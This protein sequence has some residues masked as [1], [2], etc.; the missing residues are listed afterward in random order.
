M[1]QALYKPLTVRTL[2]LTA[3]NKTRE[4]F[5]QRVGQS[6]FRSAQFMFNSVLPMDENGTEF[7]MFGG[8]G[9]RNGNAAGNRRLPNQNRN[10]IEIYPLGFL[11]E[12]QSDIY[13][14]SA[15]FG[16]RGKLKEWNVDF[17][18]TY[19]QN[20]FLFGVVNSLNASMLTG[21]PTRFNSGGTAF[22]QNTTNLDFTRQFAGLSGINLAFGAEHR[23]EKYQVIAGE[24]ASYTD[25]GKARQVGVDATGKPILVPDPTG[26]IPTRFGGADS[27]SRPGGAQVFPGYR[28][29]NAITATRSAIGAYVDGE[30]SFSKAFLVDA[31]IRF[32]NYN[33]FGSTLNQKLA[34][35][36]K[37]SDNFAIRASASTGFRAPSLHQRYLS[38]T[39]TVFRGGIPYE[40]GTFANDSRAAELLGIPKLR[41]EKSK[42]VSAGFTGTKGKFKI[43]LDGFF[44]RI[45]DRVVYTDAFTG[46]A[47]STSPV[48]QEI[49]RLLSLANAGSASFFANA[50]NTETKGVDLV[51]SYGTKLGKGNFRADFAGTHS[52]TQKVGAVMASEKLK[53]KEN[54][55]FSELSRIY[56]ERAVPRDKFNLTLTY[57][58]KKINVFVRN[59]WFG[60]VDEPVNNPAL[61]QKFGAKVI[62]DFS[63][64]YKITKELR[65]SIGSNNVLDVYP[66]KYSNIAN[67]ASNQFIYSR[68]ATQFGYNGRYVFARLELSL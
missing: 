26:S 48:D 20:Q 13:D 57:S 12:I 17:S 32:E 45:N 52:Q 67:T 56:L 4:D 1:Q 49:F 55:Y 50:I 43:T 44:T 9:Y 16:I 3:N 66:D 40:Q 11:P 64:G 33:D 37:V 27:S 68:S 59:V 38:T 31:A 5:K 19:G 2:F 29:E 63:L 62:T 65:A 10:V 8:M 22:T 47:T 42:S 18:N 21:S 51:I 41:A 60:P 15:A 28:P 46:N 25:Y 36:Y 6:L 54:V 34:A 35:R 39:S 30:V 58:I 14:K 7:Y 53:G 23:F 61:G 24:A